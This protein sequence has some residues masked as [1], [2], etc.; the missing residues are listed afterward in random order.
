MNEMMPALSDMSRHGRR[1]LPPR[2]HVV[3]V[4]EGWPR[5]PVD[6]I[7]VRV[8]RPQAPRHLLE[9]R[10][11]PLDLRESSTEHIALHISRT[12]CTSRVPIKGFGPVELP[13]IPR[14]QL[15]LAAPDLISL[16]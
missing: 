1:G 15:A 6:V 10:R 3:S 12:D 16:R 9:P 8:I 7:E 13:P 4:I 11:S 14:L 2:L 5:T